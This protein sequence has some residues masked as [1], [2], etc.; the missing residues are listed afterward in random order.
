[1]AG[2]ILSWIFDMGT[3]GFLLAI[4]CT[5]ALLVAVPLVRHVKQL[6]AV[7]VVVALVPI[8]L[9]IALSAWQYFILARPLMNNR[10]L[11][12]E[13]SSQLA[14][15]LVRPMLLGGGFTTTLAIAGTIAWAVQRQNEEEIGGAV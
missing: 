5:L 9:G 8:V 4:T 2:R 11:S 10:Q 6:T 3:P 7:Y 14:W 12:P 15:L 1:V 13:E